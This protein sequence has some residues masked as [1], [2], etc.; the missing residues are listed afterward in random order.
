MGVCWLRRT[1]N[2][3]VYTRGVWG[4][5]ITMLLET[6]LLFGI[7]VFGIEI[8]DVISRRADCDMAV[9]MDGSSMTEFGTGTITACES[10]P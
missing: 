3:P 4:S 9:R 2:K 7:P 6:F 10:V 1:V 5:S 8:C